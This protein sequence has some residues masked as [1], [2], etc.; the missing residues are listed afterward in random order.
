MWLKLGVSAA[1]VAFGVVL[2]YLAA[3]K[4]RARKKFYAQLAAFNER[5]LN[6]LGY[7]RRPLEQFLKEYEYTG[8][9]EK[10]VKTTLNPKKKI[11]APEQSLE[12]KDFVVRM[13][14]TL[15]TK[16]SL[17]GNDNKGRIFIDY[18]TRDDLARLEQMLKH[19][20]ENFK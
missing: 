16:V 10:L 12:L 5:Y 20:E 14:R 6:E 2:G 7:A 17:L 11:S 1:I 18:Y 19:L 4:F 15:G 13:Q 3:G 9:F 8:E